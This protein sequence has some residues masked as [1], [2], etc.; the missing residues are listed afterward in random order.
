MKA[1]TR[2][3]RRLAG[4]ALVLL[5]LLSGVAYG[6][7]GFGGGSMGE[8]D[9]GSM[10]T[11]VAP[12]A[13]SLIPDS[14]E[15]DA[16]MRQWVDRASLKGD[17]PIAAAAH[18]AGNAVPGLT[19]PLFASMIADIPVWRIL[20]GLLF[21]RSRIRPIMFLTMKFTGLGRLPKAGPLAAAHHYW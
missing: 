20:E 9:V 5:A 17:D 1:T 10:P 6:G 7:V 21:H 8:D 15:G 4:P 19:V 12:D 3:V 18:S 2:T 13:P 14:P 16:E 11:L